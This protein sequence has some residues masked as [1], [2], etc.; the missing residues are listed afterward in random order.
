MTDASPLAPELPNEPITLPA[1]ATAD[2]A[3]SLLQQLLASNPIAI[4]ITDAQIDDHGPRITYAN[5]T[6]RHQS[7]YELDE[8]IGQT[9]RIFQGPRTN[10]AVL[11]RL[12]SDLVAGRNFQGETVNY[13]KDGTP[14]V[15]RWSIVP[16]LH[17]LAIVRYLS[18]QIALSGAPT[19]FYPM[20]SMRFTTRD[21]F[22]AIFDSAEIGIAIIDR[23]SRFV[24]VNH[25]LCRFL[26]RPASELI[27]RNCTDF[28]DDPDSVSE[29]VA[30]IEG[31][32]AGVLDFHADYHLHRSNG[33]RVTLR[34][35]CKVL[36]A[37]DG[38]KYLVWAVAD[39]TSKLVLEQRLQLQELRFDLAI[40][41]CG[42]GFWDYDCRTREV[43]F[44][45][46]W[47]AMLG[48]EDAELA[49]DPSEW[50]SRLHPD[51]FPRVQRTLNDFL[52]GRLDDYRIEY[53]LRHR[54]GH[55]RTILARG[56]AVRDEHRRALR[57]AGT[58]TDVSDRR[59]LE[60]QLR[61]GQK[62][63]AIGQLAGGIAHDFN[64]I[65]TI[66]LGNLD[67]IRLPD[68]DRHRPYVAAAT[69][70]ALRAAE[71]TSKLLGF[72]R[73]SPLA[74]ADVSVA[75]IVYDVAALL[76]PTI[77]P[78][79]ALTTE[80]GG[81]LPPVRG[82]ANALMQVVLNMALNARDAMPNGGR[83]TIAAEAVRCDA[84]NVPAQAA[85]TPGDY[86]RIVVTDTGLG[87]D[88][89]TRARLF[90]PFFTTKPVGKGT[91]MGLAV[92]YGTVRQHGG[93]IDVASEPQRGSR[94]TVYLPA[95]ESR[96]SILIVDDDDSV[97][98]F[99]RYCLE[100][101]GWKVVE[102]DGGDSALARLADAGPFD[103]VLQDLNMPG[104]SGEGWFRKIRGAAP[105]T[106]LC[107]ISGGRFEDRWQ[108]DAD[109]TLSKPFDRDRLV[110]T[111]DSLV[112]RGW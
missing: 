74:R 20:A 12:R 105:G 104:D 38:A 24:R 111:V 13:R 80:A 10:R 71:L 72:A 76:K 11:D 70:G 95:T 36:E 17:G 60:E 63:D 51:D 19:P 27:G 25:L 14:Y 85:A 41:G 77:D 16:V 40:H 59:Q 86:V 54:D 67:L 90:E 26:D 8:L 23:D 18:Y 7:G 1:D 49:N 15:V 5:R 48:Y 69:A 9:L 93:W 35:G 82:D 73:R 89:S 55:Y 91:G 81:S 97:R 37:D 29:T 62:L 4:L 106:R 78:R 107:L 42:L 22:E 32:F 6:F 53:R 46:G 84:A 34:G 79:I 52:A 112:N 94:F 99:A 30:T 83:L 45:P 109:A 47:K 44:S 50:E 103:L 65:L 96:K 33:S 21:P 64:N 87:M 75:E 39:V 31:V 110:L 61:Q 102:A 57:F 100:K 58:H 28:C 68:G 2:H 56:A 66:V 88:E 98:S 108:L 43:Y 101:A 92:A 3:L